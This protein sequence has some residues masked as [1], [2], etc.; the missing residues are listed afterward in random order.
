MSIGEPNFAHHLSQLDQALLVRARHCGGLYIY[1][2]GLSSKEVALAV[3]KEC[4]IPAH[5]T[6][7]G[8]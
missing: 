7:Q 3:G 6:L 4:C 5:M 8:K 1:E 2:R